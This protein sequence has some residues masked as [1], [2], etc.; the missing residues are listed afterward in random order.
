MLDTIAITLL[1]VGLGCAVFAALTWLADG[2][3][4]FKDSVHEA[5]NRYIDEDDAVPGIH[6]LEEDL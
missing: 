2:I 4:E 1:F 6:D 3:Q 5:E